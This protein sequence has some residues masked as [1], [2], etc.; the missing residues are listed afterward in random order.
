MAYT[1]Y[2]TACGSVADRKHQLGKAVDDIEKQLSQMD[3]EN[4]EVLK[5][6][7]AI[8]ADMVSKINQISDDLSG[9]SFE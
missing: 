1:T 4:N 8:V 7:E 3:L 6:M 5:T 2:G 9:Y